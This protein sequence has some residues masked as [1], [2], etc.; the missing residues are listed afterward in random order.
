MKHYWRQTLWKSCE[1]VLKTY[2]STISFSWLFNQTLW[3]C[4][5]KRTWKSCEN[6]A[7]F[8]CFEKVV[9][10]VY[11]K[12]EYLQLTPVINLKMYYF[13]VRH[14]LLLILYSIRYLLI[15]H[16]PQLMA[17]ILIKTFK[18]FYTL[19]HKEILMPCICGF[20]KNWHSWAQ[21]NILV[22]NSSLN[23]FLPILYKFI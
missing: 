13:V 17:C 15:Y 16:L 12:D 9:T 22:I 10:I 23:A 14:C 4:V 11:K 20:M 3:K 18:T 7:N 2:I 5:M 21:K 8:H 19:K 1:N 6:V